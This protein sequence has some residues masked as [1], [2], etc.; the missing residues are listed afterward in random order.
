VFAIPAAAVIPFNFSTGAPDGRMA[1]ASRPANAGL[2][3]IE[4]ESADDFILSDVTTINHATFTGLLPSGAL[5]STIQQVSV[6]IYRVFPKDSTNPPSGNVPTRVN[7]PADVAF[8]AR[9]FGAGNLTFSAT[10]LNASFSASNSVV[11]G[12]HPKPNQTTGGEGAVSGEEVSFDVTFSPPIQLPADH[13]FFVPKVGLSSGNFLWLSTSAPVAPDLQSWIRDA[14]LDPDWL[15]IGT[16][17]VGGVTPPTFNASF[18]LDGQSGI[19]FDVPTLGRLALLMLA[20][21][22][23]GAG[24]VARRRA[25]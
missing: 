24:L 15:R 9:D 8:A 25:E 14:N 2:G 4:I 12:I 7:S 21:L 11:N 19:D 5:L 6:E 1:T 20:V 13:Y 22:L 16:D 18:S 17:I 23:L 3:Q 10:V